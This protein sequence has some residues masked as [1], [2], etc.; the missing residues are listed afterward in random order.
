[1]SS[2]KFLFRFPD[3]NS[4]WSFLEDLLWPAGPVCPACDSVDD[5]ARWKPRPHRW[6]CRYCGKQFRVAQDTA[7]FGRHLSMHRWFS[8]IYL[9]AE[10][11]R[12][13]AAEL[14]RQLGLRQNTALSVRHRVQRMMTEDAKLIERMI[15]AVDGPNCST[16]APGK[17]GRKRRKSHLNP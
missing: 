1:M 15:E 6:Q 5:A 8:A 10:S 3:D 12:I 16:K 7:L 9:M 13:S 17:K 4:C 14:G 11:P 2:L